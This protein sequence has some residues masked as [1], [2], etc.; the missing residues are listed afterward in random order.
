MTNNKGDSGSP[1]LTPLLHLK[2]LPGTPFRS[3]ADEPDDKIQ[4][5]QDIHLSGKLK[6]CNIS[7]IVE[8]STVSN[9]FSKSN[10]RI[11]ASLLD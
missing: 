3:T 11:I 6:C 1:C 5:I 4:W 2:N 9:A 7:R 10:L 8:C